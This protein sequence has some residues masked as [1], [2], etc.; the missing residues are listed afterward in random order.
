MLFTALAFL[1]MHQVTPRVAVTLDDVRNLPS[2]ELAAGVLP[3]EIARRIVGGVAWRLFIPGQHWLM[4]FWEQARPTAPMICLRAQ[5]SRAATNAR[6]AERPD[7]PDEIAME[8]GELQHD[9]ALASTYPEPATPQSCDKAKGYATTYP[10]NLAATTDAIRTLNTA[11]GHAAAD[12]ALPFT[13]ECSSKE[14][15]ACADPRDALANLPLS[16]LSGVSFSFA[17]QG[18]YVV[19]VVERDGTTTYKS[20]WVPAPPDENPSDT[21]EFGRSGRDGKSWRV[22]MRSKDGRL[23]H[24]QMRRSMISYH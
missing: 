19:D 1:T 7:K 9:F 17:Y 23:E 5:H 15:D 10:V 20:R 18:K 8:I 2:S 16:V 11:M 12:S 13:L 4:R 3:P 24:V 6:A 22:V 14:D 21:I